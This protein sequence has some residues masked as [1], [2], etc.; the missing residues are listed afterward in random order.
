MSF[1]EEDLTKSI[2]I[3]SVAMDPAFMACESIPPPAPGHT[4]GFSGMT[5]R[6]RGMGRPFADGYARAP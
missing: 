2:V 1:V 4:A 6:K 5:A 3:P